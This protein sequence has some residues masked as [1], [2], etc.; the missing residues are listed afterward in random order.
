[1]SSGN[2]TYPP[3]SSLN[4]THDC[5]L[6]SQF[7]TSWYQSLDRHVYV[8]PEITLLLDYFR[9]ALPNSTSTITKGQ[10]VDWYY[11]TLHNSTEPLFVDPQFM[12]HVISDPLKICNKEFCSGLGYSGNPD[13]GG[14][15]VSD[16]SL[17]HLVS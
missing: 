8:G 15:G 6:T 13:I 11:A 1:M 10:I 12:T 2:F 17:L 4:F 5:T 9:A 3:W 16:T 14:I 7:L